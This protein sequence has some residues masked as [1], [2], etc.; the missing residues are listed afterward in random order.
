[1]TGGGG[2]PFKPGFGLSGIFRSSKSVIPTG[3]DH[4][5]SD[6]LRSGGTLRFV[7]ASDGEGRVFQDPKTEKGAG[8]FRRAVELPHSS[9]NRA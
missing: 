2:G 9:Q 4:R 7:S 1:M 3:A 5:E 8:G 6:V